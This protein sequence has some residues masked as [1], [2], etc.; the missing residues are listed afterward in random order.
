MGIRG[1]I[2]GRA[3]CRLSFVCFLVCCCLVCFFNL[4]V[5]FMF[6]FCLFFGG[7]FVIF[8]CLWFVVGLLFS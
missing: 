4:F 1:K 8:V 3:G 7:G 2:E 5:C 6:V